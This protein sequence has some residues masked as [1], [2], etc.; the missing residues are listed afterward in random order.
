MHVCACGEAESEKH[1]EGE[2]YEIEATTTAPGGKF[3]VCPDCGEVIT[4]EVY[5]QLPAPTAN[6]DINNDGKV[7]ISDVTDLLKYLAGTAELAGNGDLDGDEK[8][9]ISDVTELLKILAGAPA[10]A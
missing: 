1:T 10:E 3:Y 4:V 9:D 2:I 8:V 7:D 6:G 5:E